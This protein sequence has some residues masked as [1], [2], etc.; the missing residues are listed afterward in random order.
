[1]PGSTLGLRKAVEP[2]EWWAGGVFGSLCGVRTS[3]PHV[4]LTYDDGPEP[5]GTDEVLAA[6]EER[7]ATA[8]FF[9]LMSRARRHPGL[10]HE[11]LAA[12]HEVGLHGLDHRRVTTLTESDVIARARDGRAELEDLIGRSVTW[13]RPPYGAQSFRT[14]RAATRAGLV[15]VLWGPSLLDWLPVTDDERLGSAL[16]DSTRGSVLLAHDGFAGPEDGVD[17][18]PPPDVRRG[19]LTRRLLDAYENSG[20]TGR[21]LRDALVDGVPTWRAWFRR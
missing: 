16:G 19:A 9:V 3:A 6:L 13:Y 20:F 15:P 11:V 1:M 5:G 7:R 10:L 8:T 12:G 18:G 21:S 17:D 4:V 14:W 2:L